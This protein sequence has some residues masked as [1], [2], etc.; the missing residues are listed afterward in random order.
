MSSFLLMKQIVREN[1]YIFSGIPGYLPDISQFIQTVG[2]P[3]EYGPEFNTGLESS[4][5][6]T[7]I[8]L[9]D[10]NLP[11]IDPLLTIKIEEHNKMYVDRQNYYEPSDI[12]YNN[13]GNTPKWEPPVFTKIHHDYTYGYGDIAESNRLTLLN[14]DN[15]E[16]FT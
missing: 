15:F 12:Q 13:Y 8:D 1:M 2:F 4:W 14:S 7:F 3:P 11:H 5:G 16:V 9:D 10:H 6:S